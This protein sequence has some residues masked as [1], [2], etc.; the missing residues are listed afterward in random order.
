MKR[1]ST[2]ASRTVSTAPTVFCAPWRVNW[3]IWFPIMEV[4]GRGRDEVLRVVVA[5]H[6]QRDE[7]D[8]GEDPGHRERQRDP[9]ESLEGARAEIASRLDLALVDPVER[10]VERAG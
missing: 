4:C 9:P 5:E 8:A 6:G 2:S 10:R 1:R 3:S 7:D